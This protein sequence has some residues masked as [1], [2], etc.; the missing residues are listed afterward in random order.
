MR[1]F[2]CQLHGI[3]EM[4]RRNCSFQKTAEEFCGRAYKRL[5][6]RYQVNKTETSETRIS[7]ASNDHSLT[8][9][10]ILT[11]DSQSAFTIPPD[12]AANAP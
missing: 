9:T 4:S 7:T 6:V 3:I 1:R 10:Q 12:P 5:S 11:K 2:C 8:Q